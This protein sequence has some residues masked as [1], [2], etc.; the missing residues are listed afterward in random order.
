MPSSR[1]MDSAAWFKVPPPMELTG[2]S[3]VAKTTAPAPALTTPAPVVA[4]PTDDRTTVVPAVL[5]SVAVPA[6]LSSVAAPVDWSNVAAPVEWS[7][8]KRPPVARPYT[9]D[10]TV[11]EMLPT[12]YLSIG[13]LQ[14]S[15]KLSYLW[16]HPRK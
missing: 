4:V 8:E 14:W 12:V 10:W 15:E 3:L 1:P 6:D 5:S 16:R 2:W 13:P 7:N 11:V 9:I